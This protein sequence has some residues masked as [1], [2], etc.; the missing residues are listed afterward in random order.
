MV[1]FFVLIYIVFIEAVVRKGMQEM[2]ITPKKIQVII[3]LTIPFSEGRLIMC[4]EN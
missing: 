4:V 1:V 3:T 2:R